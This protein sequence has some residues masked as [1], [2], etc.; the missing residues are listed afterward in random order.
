MQKEFSVIMRESSN[1]LFTL[2]IANNAE[3]NGKMALLKVED[4]DP[5]TGNF[6]SR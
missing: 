3:L 2:K 6:A 4:L 5:V 1:A